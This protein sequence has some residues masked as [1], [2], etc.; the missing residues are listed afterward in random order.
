MIKK[1]FQNLLCELKLVDFVNIKTF[2]LASWVEEKSKEIDL[3][4]KY[5]ETNDK[6]ILR[7][8]VNSGAVLKVN[9]AHNIITTV[10]RA[11]IAKSLTNGRVTAPIINYGALGT[12][13]SP[14]PSNSSTQ[15]GN[16]VFRKVPA[17][18]SNDNNIA[19]IDFFFAAADCSGTFTEFGNFIDGTATANSGKLFSYIATGGWAKTTA[20]SLFVSCQ[21]NIN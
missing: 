18:Q 12:V 20:Q 13:A 10:G 6:N 7:N 8:L 11:E 1:I 4:R 5:I 16:E 21:Y 19:Y 14:S 3:L 9:K 2:Q 17:S 15:L